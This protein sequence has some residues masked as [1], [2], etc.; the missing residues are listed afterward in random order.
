MF[1]I[2]SNLPPNVS[3]SRVLYQRNSLILKC[4][5]R[6]LN[7]FYCEWIFRWLTDNSNNRPDESQ[8]LFLW[9]AP[10]NQNLL[11]NSQWLPLR[12]STNESR[13]RHRHAFLFLQR[14]SRRFSFVPFLVFWKTECTLLQFAISIL[15][16]LYCISLLHFGAE[17]AS[18]SAFGNKQSKQ[19]RWHLGFL[20]TGSF[21]VN[22]STSFWKKSLM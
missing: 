16:S 2:I 12:P 17:I 22:L 15:L 7:S 3:T 18:K 10:F 20:S 21:K 11:S 19:Y 14:Q 1:S 4:K 13:S 5:T 6:I 8:L 9:S